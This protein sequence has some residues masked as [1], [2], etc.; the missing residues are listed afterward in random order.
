[1]SVLE[2]AEAGQADGHRLSP[3]QD[4]LTL[5]EMPGRSLESTRLETEDRGCIL[6]T[7]GKDLGKGVQRFGRVL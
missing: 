5:W 4:K 6:S 3:R 1:M 7:S 2:R